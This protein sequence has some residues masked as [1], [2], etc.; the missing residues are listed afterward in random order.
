MESQGIQNSN[1]DSELPK[2]FP[3]TR[4]HSSVKRKLLQA[5]MLR[6][7]HP[8]TGVFYETEQENIMPQIAF[9]F[10][11]TPQIK[12][13]LK[14]QDSKSG[15][16]TLR[17]TPNKHFSP[18]LKKKNSR[19]SSSYTFSDQKENSELGCTKTESLNL[20][21]S[22]L[23]ELWSAVLNQEDLKELL[24]KV[25]RIEAV[26][27]TKGKGFN[28]TIPETKDTP[29]QILQNFRKF[30]S[31]AS[32]DKVPQGN[33][34]LGII[35][36]ARNTLKQEKNSNPSMYKFIQRSINY[37]SSLNYTGKVRK[38]RRVPS[39]HSFEDNKSAK[40]EQEKDYTPR[41]ALLEAKNS[42]LKK[43]V[44]Q[45]CLLFRSTQPVFTKQENL[46]KVNLCSPIDSQVVTEES[47]NKQATINLSSQLDI[48]IEKLAPSIFDGEHKEEYL[49]CDSQVPKPDKPNTSSDSVVI[50]EVSS[51]GNSP[52]ESFESKGKSA[53]LQRYFTKSPYESSR[54]Q[55]ENSEIEISVSPEVN[56]SKHSSAKHPSSRKSF[57][58]NSRPRSR[59]SQ[60]SAQSSKI[61]DL[62]QNIQ[63][64]MKHLKSLESVQK[65]I[66]WE[67][68]RQRKNKAQQEEKT[69]Y[70]EEFKLNKELEDR[71]QGFLQSKIKAEKEEMKKFKQ[72]EHEEAKRIKYLKNREKKIESL[73]ELRRSQEK[74]ELLKGSKEVEQQLSRKT[75]KDFKYMND[76]AI[77]KNLVQKPDS[78]EQDEQAIVDR[79]AEL[80]SMHKQITQEKQRL[81]QLLKKY[82][83]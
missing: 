15:K 17:N 77:F 75:N 23:H 4:S 30:I 60:N 53:L 18:V 66:E 34:Y 28:Q 54:V 65:K 61:S 68:E 33:S 43:S 67:E 64:E 24:E 3:Q 70:I 71:F 29:H 73:D 46:D 13:K 56:S 11:Q 58:A 32:T 51:K 76:D 47:E 79:I 35:K 2:E 80:S 36:R 41:F 26:A 44:S 48:A 12:P 38:G 21:E 25:N 8:N 74:S 39:L 5:A 40:A 63:S 82:H 22:T 69:R 72:Q 31:L 16:L 42:P 1:L 59:Q 19:R 57:Q 45:N 10:N 83:K 27:D 20:L 6:D 50:E 14:K 81:Q 52:L 62:E 55:T 7:N 9:S 37:A 78:D 49:W